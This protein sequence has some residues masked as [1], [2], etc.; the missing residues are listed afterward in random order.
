M[1][2]KE[3]RTCGELLE[4]STENFYLTQAAN[5]TLRFASPDCRPCFLKKDR[6]DRLRKKEETHYGS[7]AIYSKPNTYVDD[8]QKDQTFQFLTLLGWKF[9]EEKGIWYD[10]IK[11]TEDG[12]FIGVWKLKPKRNKLIIKFTEDTFV[13]FVFPSKAHSRDITKDEMVK[14]MIKDYYVSDLSLKEILNKYDVSESYLKYYIKLYKQQLSGEVEV[15]R[16]NQTLGRERRKYTI[17]RPPILDIPKVKLSHQRL[18]DKYSPEFVRQ[19]QE[20]YFIHTMKYRDVLDKYADEESFAKYIIHKTMLLLKE[21]RN[22]K[23]ST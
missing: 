18:I 20:D 22:D 13:P 17:Y 15:K 3:C 23:R 11:K 16:R 19:I 14:N 8:I 5:G 12:E 2:F 1:K 10:G 7:N 21:R 4:V 9:N 6:L